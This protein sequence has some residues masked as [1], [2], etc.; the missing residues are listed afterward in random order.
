MPLADGETKLGRMAG[1]Q[2]RD[3]GEGGAG[4]GGAADLVPARRDAGLHEGRLQPLPRRGPRQGRL[5]PVALRLRP[6]R[7]P[8]SASPARCPAAASTSPSRRRAC[9]SRSRRRSAAHRRQ[10]VRERKRAVQ[11]AS[12]AGSR[13]ARRTTSPTSPTSHGVELLPGKRVL[14]GKGEKS[15]FTVRAKYSDGTD[16][17]VTDLALFLTNNDD[18]AE[19]RRTACDRRRARRGVRHGPLRDLHRRR[20]GHR[21]SR[22]G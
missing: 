12:S 15:S 7:R 3:P 22:R 1:P 8:L 6:R 18:S 19:D 11:H 16:R 14:D 17:D 4:E 20:A 10:A 9:C 21:P 5:P 13:R 2:Q